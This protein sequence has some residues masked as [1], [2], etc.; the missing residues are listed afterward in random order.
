M[1]QCPDSCRVRLEHLENDM[2]DSKGVHSELFSR[3]NTIN[4]NVSTRVKTSTLLT[5]AVVIVCILGG[6]FTLLYNQGYNIGNKI[7]DVH[8]R[9]TGVHDQVHD[10]EMKVISVQEQVK[11]QSQAQEMMKS[12][13]Q[14]IKKD[15]G[16]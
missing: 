4:D 12:D 15:N 8:Q 10:V 3:I 16:D 11:A 6:A 13:I 5:V 14:E 9:I 2:K 1:N 7:G